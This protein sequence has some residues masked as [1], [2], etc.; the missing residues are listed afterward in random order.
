MGPALGRHLS[1]AEEEQLFMAIAETWST[2]H[3]QCAEQKA[4]V[5]FFLPLVIL[6]VRNALE[7]VFRDAFPTYFAPGH[8][9]GEAAL[10]EVDAIAV[11]LM[12]PGEYAS[13]IS[14][15]ESTAEGLR[16]AARVP[17]NLRK[18]PLYHAKSS[19]VAHAV[20]KPSHGPT[21]AVHEREQQRARL[22]SLIQEQ[23]LQRQQRHMERAMVAVGTSSA[24]SKAERLKDGGGGRG[25][26]VSAAADA[27]AA[28]RDRRQRAAFAVVATGPGREKHGAVDLHLAGATVVESPST[29]ATHLSA[30]GTFASQRQERLGARERDQAL[31][32]LSEARMQSRQ[33]AAALR[34][35]SS[36]AS[37]PSTRA[38]S[39]RSGVRRGGRHS[40]GTTVRDPDHE[41][42]SYVDHLL[43]AGSG[44]S[45]VLG[46]LQRM[47]PS[48][49][50]GSA[51]AG[52]PPAADARDRAGSRAV[53]AAAAAKEAA[54]A[55]REAEA[56]AREAAVAARE[57]VRPRGTLPHRRLA[58]VERPA[59]QEGLLPV[60]PTGPA[61]PPGRLQL[62]AAATVDQEGQQ[63]P[64]LSKHHRFQLF[65]VALNRL[66]TKYSR[67][68]VLRSMHG[69]LTELLA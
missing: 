38:S 40:R 17:N 32:A 30:A 54:A 41:R 20:P 21:R 58:A 3:Q 61:R 16:L 49:A 26:E 6:S 1:T 7:L 68:P 25:A 24:S 23:S 37:R 18:R 42:R 8:D 4:R 9:A 65:Q 36:A 69:D 14:G 55:A 62:P 33:Q 45:K 43:S 19:L 15:L 12:D 50:A 48:D 2:V 31:E 46:E 57:G 56:A 5:V 51:V 34:P 44:P 47:L 13:R 64:P 35:G 52:G 27:G 10:R 22:R 59:R 66:R 63:L 60:R 39:A 29:A 28:V 53:L 11:R 67:D